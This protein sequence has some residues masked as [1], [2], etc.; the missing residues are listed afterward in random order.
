MY[1]YQLC[2]YIYIYQHAFYIDMCIPN[3]FLMYDLFEVK[4][5]LRNR[6][7]GMSSQWKWL[8]IKKRQ[9]K[10]FKKVSKKLRQMHSQ[11]NWVLIVSYDIYE[12]ALLIMSVRLLWKSTHSSNDGDQRKTSNVLTV[13]YY[14][15]TYK[16]QSESTPYSLPECPGTPCLKQAPY[17]KFTWL[18]DQLG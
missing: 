4:W 18:L 7:P 13:C 5:T 15:V 11:K 12:I 14:N 1:I 17:L 16:F 8:I 9:L 10:Q 3:L 2:I 6:A